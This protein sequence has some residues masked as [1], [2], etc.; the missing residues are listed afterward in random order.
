MAMAVSET[1]ESLTE[2]EVPAEVSRRGFFRVG[3]AFIAAVATLSSAKS[4]S[5]DCQG[6]PC[7]NL[8]SCT[9]CSPSGGCGGGWYCPPGYTQ[10]YWTCTRGGTTCTCGECSAGSNCF[11]GPWACSIYNCY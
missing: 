9:Q 6:S 10:T 3:S 4:A 1:A 7:C 11:S 8:A 2:S 5:A